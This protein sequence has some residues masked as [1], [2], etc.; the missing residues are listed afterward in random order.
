M[1]NFLFALL[2]LL[3]TACTQTPT[4]APVYDIADIEP[5]ISRYSTP[6][7]EETPVAENTTVSDWL[8]PVAKRY[9]HQFNLS[10]KGVDI[11]GTTGE[12]IF[13]TAAGKVVYCGEGLRGYGK[14][15]IIKHNQSY[16]SV[17]A[18]N[19]TILV[20]QGAIVKQGQSIAQMGNTGTN[21]VKLHFEIRRLG[22]PLN[23]LI[24]VYP[25]PV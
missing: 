18:H 9:K 3:L 22:K 23:P 24:L 10:N 25:K 21:S 16:L 7:Q 20:K 8:P 17:Y 2:L 19:Q 12:P 6:A 5:I 1:K 13:A 15:I 14:L 4:Y 11:S